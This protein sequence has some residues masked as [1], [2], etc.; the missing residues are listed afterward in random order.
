M[1][2]SSVGSNVNSSGGSQG[3]MNGGKRTPSTL[4]QHLQLGGTCAS[5][6]AH[7]QAQLVSYQQ[8]TNSPAVELA[9]G[10]AARFNVSSHVG[11]GA[12]SGQSCISL[13]VVASKQAATAIAV[14]NAMA[15]SKTNSQRHPGA[16]IVHHVRPNQVG[17]C[18]S[19]DQQEH[20]RACQ[21]RLAKSTG[22]VNDTDEPD[23]RKQE[24][25]QGSLTRLN[26][27]SSNNI[28]GSISSFG[29]NDSCPNTSQENTPCSGPNSKRHRIFSEQ[30]FECPLGSDSA[31]WNQSVYSI[32]YCSDC[33][34][35]YC[36]YC[37]CQSNGA[38]EFASLDQDAQNV[39]IRSTQ[40]AFEDIELLD[41]SLTD[42]HRAI[43]QAQQTTSSS[44]DLSGESPCAS[45]AL[46]F[47]PN[48]RRKSELH[49]LAPRD[50]S[51]HQQTHFQR[52]ATRRS[53]TM[54]M[55]TIGIFTALSSHRDVDQPRGGSK[56]SRSE[57]EEPN[58][59]GAS[60]VAYALQAAASSA[61]SACTIEARLAVG[62]RRPGQGRRTNATVSRDGCEASD[63]ENESR[64]SKHHNQ[65][66]VRRSFRR[67]LASRSAR[68]SSTASV[69]PN[70]PSGKS[71]VRRSTRRQP[72]EREQTSSSNE[73][74]LEACHPVEELPMEDLSSRPDKWTARQVGGFPR[75]ESQRALNEPPIL[76]S[77]SDSKQMGDEQETPRE[78]GA[79]QVAMIGLALNRAHDS[80]SVSQASDT[81][82]RDTSAD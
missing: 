73:H 22:R 36:G 31:L 29:V 63:E 65:E 68:G 38:E 72:E 79:N 62:D 57:E 14:S 58:P 75:Q 10:R 43:R 76:R 32:D 24:L 34:P 12:P 37:S 51:Q 70:N 21:T 7:Q 23:G 42:S 46:S 18:L 48:R 11:L 1:Q 9:A 16:K 54:E 60:P 20:F 28:N 78:L 27:S 67:D 50:S 61:L 77:N 52:Q 17:R 26:A 80:G 81:K 82:S 39:A 49:S 69:D 74:E 66:N 59:V 41:S 44:L 40:H 13:G 56:K 33:C 45:L 30:D 19:S 47:V 35:S 4:S 6:G 15:A 2:E 71:R 8:Q 55:K 64:S 3:V 53:Q 25:E 5:C